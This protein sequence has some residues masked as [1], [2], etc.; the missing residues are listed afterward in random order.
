[1][2]ND[3]INLKTLVISKETLEKIPARVAAHYG[4]LPVSYDGGRLQVAATGDMSRQA[5]EELRVVLHEEIDF[6]T[7]DAS[8]LIGA[9]SRYYG[10]GAGTIEKLTEGHAGSETAALEGENI[11]GSDAEEATV[12][13]LVNELLADAMR[14]R[15]SDIHIE[16]FGNVFRI[17]YRVD[18]LLRE[19]KVPEQIRL[20]ASA[21][22]SRVKIMAHLD[23]GEKR[24]PQD[25]RIKVQ[26]QGK[27]LDLRVSILPSS[28]G[29]AIVIRI[30]K[31]LEL[32]ALDELGFED[33]ALAWFKSVFKLPHGLILV[34]GPTGSGK[35]TTLYASLK[36]LNS[37][38]RK[39]ITIEDPIEYKLPG[40]VQMQ[41][42]N[43]IGFDFAKA[44]RAMLRHDPDCLMV[45]EI[46]DK[47]TAEMAV[48]S[49]LTGHLVFSTLHTND[50]ASS[51]ARLIEMGIEPHLIASALTGVVAQR[52]VRKSCPPCE[53]CGGSGYF[54]R[55]VVYEIMPVSEAV[56]QAILEKASAARLKQILS[57][58]GMSEM[59]EIGTHKVQAGQTSE[60]EVAR[61]MAH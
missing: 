36:E 51:V 15:A 43:K 30:L 21:I 13:K 24:L 18:G 35:T 3:C 1:M 58:E 61:V 31:S 6:Q 59:R 57:D 42:H 49:A 28:F 33:Q 53:K 22:I 48:R 16:P 56:R 14:Q 41:T 37:M 32:L 23:I 44:L 29:E 45:G 2:K 46:R 17:R 47:E 20:L 5:R 52:L 12:Q 39:I 38:E 9:I 50:A 7:V 19:A 40:I 4:V 54:G 11:D 60:E 26:Q 55:T 34:T 8:D 25:G 27:E 10:I